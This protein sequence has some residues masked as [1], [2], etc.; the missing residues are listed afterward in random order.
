[1]VSP[2]SFVETPEEADP[3]VAGAVASL[4]PS[5]SFASGVAFPHP[6]ISS[7][8]QLNPIASPNP[9]HFGCNI[10]IQCSF[11]I[12][13]GPWRECEID[14]IG[15]FGKIRR[16][17]HSIAEKLAPFDTAA[18]VPTFPLS[19][20]PVSLAYELGLSVHV[21]R[22][23]SLLFARI[24]LE[25]DRVCAADLVSVRIETAALRSAAGR[26]RNEGPAVA[27]E[28]R[29]SI[30][31]AGVRS[32]CLARVVG[33]A[34][35]RIAIEAMVS[36]QPAAGFAPAVPPEGETTTPAF[37]GGGV[38]ERA[39]VVDRW[40]ARAGVAFDGELVVALVGPFTPG[41]SAP[42]SAGNIAP[43][44]RIAEERVIAARADQAIGDVAYRPRH[45][46]SRAARVEPR[47]RSR[48]GEQQCL[49]PGPDAAGC[50]PPRV[51]RSAHDERIVPPGVRPE[52][53]HALSRTR[54]DSVALE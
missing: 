44:R 31:G 49:S 16:R 26:R 52:A 24:A 13:L 18:H 8:A 43:A 1:M 40:I 11:Q 27:L 10:N 38:V 50:L 7:E 36:N 51:L 33:F 42:P 54:A 20:I 37:E 32:S 12:D 47:D 46:S 6:A 39:C 5:A 3:S 29:R 35:C 30:D 41:A 25:G 17:G 53:G 21:A 19:C 22:D 4:E 34:H 2:A 45:G 23:A 15:I 14:A 48:E 28:H 9:H